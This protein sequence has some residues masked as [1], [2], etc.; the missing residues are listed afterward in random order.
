MS[1]KR[2]STV[3]AMALSAFAINAHATATAA[4]AAKLCKD[5]T[6]VGAVKAGNKEGTIPEWTGPSNFTEEQKH[7]THAKLED[8][9]KNHPKEIEDLFAKQ[10]GPDKMKILFTITKANMAQYADKLTE[11]QK[12]ML[13][14]YPSFK[15]IVYTS[16]RTAF[17]PDAIYKATVANATSA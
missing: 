10:A 16:V 4:E 5:L 6:C 11:G 2:T 7:Y 15:M 9:R 13:T 3:L 17:Y 1:L 8:L 12:A 14:Q